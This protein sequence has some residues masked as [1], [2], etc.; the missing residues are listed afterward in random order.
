MECQ[1]HNL[2]NLFAQLGKPS[3][4]A[5]IAHFIETHGPLPESQRFHEAPFWTPSQSAFLCESLLEDADWADA[6]DELNTRL[7][8]P[9]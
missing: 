8:D 3:D 4:E 6:A 2:S 1:F 5:S 9:N 7:H